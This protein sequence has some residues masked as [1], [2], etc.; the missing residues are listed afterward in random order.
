[1]PLRRRPGRLPW[2]MGTAAPADWVSTPSPRPRSPRA[3]GRRMV[4]V[5]NY[6]A[7]FGDNYCIGALTPGTIFPTETPYTIWP[8]VARTA[9]HRLARLPGH[10]C[11][12]QRQPAHRPGH[13]RVP[14]RDVRL[15]DE[16][17]RQARQRHRRH[18]QHDR[19]RRGPPRPAC[20]Q[21]RLAVQRRRRR[22]HRADQLSDPAELRHRRRLRDVQLGVALLLRQH[23]LQEPS[24]R[25]LRTSSSSTGRST[26]SSSR[27]PCSTYC[28][29]GSR[30]G[31]EVVSSDPY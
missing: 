7:S 15:H 28:A 27:S 3:A 1:M 14:P 10:V 4:P 18:E 31:G 30:N 8:P 6:L 26:S 21:Q 2:R 11:R 17:G 29:L 20:R 9:A 24:P 16:P 13:A 23:G 25:R 5:M 22:H 19:G 12:H